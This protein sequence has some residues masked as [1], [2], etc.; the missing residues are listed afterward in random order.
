[1][2]ALVLATGA[3]ASSCVSLPDEG[4]KVTLGTHVEDWRD[5]VIYQV[6]VDRFANGDVNNDYLVRPGA[7][8]RYQGGDWKGLEDHLDYV[9]ELGVT[10]LWISPVVR[11]V[12]TDADVD[13]Y[14]GYWAQ[15]LTETNP[16]FGD[17]VSLRSLVKKAH[18]QGLKVV[19]DI[20]TNHMG[21]V[22]F[23]DMNLNGKAD[24][25]IGGTGTSS[26]VTRVSE[27]DPDWDARGVQAETS[28]GLAGRA[29]VV[30]FQDPAIQRIPPR[31]G[32]L[33]RAE[34]YHG[35]G[36]ILNYDEQKQTMLGD[37]PGGLKDVATEIPEVRDTM[38]DAYTRWAELTDL[39]GFRIDTVKH[40]EHEF[41]Q[42]FA[43]GVRARLARQ[44][45]KKFLMFG[46]AFDGNDELL[47]TFTR[48]G[49]L[50]SVFY[51]SQHYQVFRDIFQLAHDPAAQRGTD[52]IEKLWAARSKNWSAEPQDEGTGVAPQKMPVNFMDNHDVARFLFGALGDVPALRNALTLLL[53]EE[54]LPCIYYGT[55]LDFAGGNDPANREVLWTTGF[56]K[57]GDTFRHVAK[58]LKTRKAVP[59]LRRGDT[60][61][62]WS[63]AHTAQEEDAG[64][65]AYERGGGDAPDSYALVALNTNSAKASSTS[66]G[67]AVMKTGKASAK[68][69]DVLDP[70]RPTFTTNADGTLKVSIP[71][72]SARLLL[73]ESEVAA[74]GL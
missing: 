18:D 13:A 70:A 5:E 37:F 35:F 27:F 12:E 15:D 30:F 69:V 33:G 6:L 17:L 45:K 52:Q 44:G 42:V 3:S 57:T 63:T 58:I 16:H 19:L 59:A 23:Y 28:L 8:A 34:A 67:G 50:D 55:E 2:G 72:Q 51:F 21:Q 22:F 41:W 24:I 54:G 4:T 38:V 74:L 40:V 68:L 26:A 14:H 66:D 43:Q 53:T 46:E 71:A 29:P 1:M 20:V 32:I 62:L 56:P 9:K 10:T 31:P 39:D 7:L 65:I 73:L 64:I 36:R 60:R 48:K 25:Y 49:E 61:V 47:G 11:N